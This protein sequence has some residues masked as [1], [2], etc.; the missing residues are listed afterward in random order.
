MNQSPDIAFSPYGWAYRTGREEALH[1]TGV[2]QEE[3]AIV[4][5]ELLPI[6]FCCPK[7]LKAVAFPLIFNPT[8]DSLVGTAPTAGI[9]VK[10]LDHK[11]CNLYLLHD[12]EDGLYRKSR[13]PR[14]IGDRVVYYSEWVQ[15]DHY[16]QVEERKVAFR[17]NICKYTEAYIE[18]HQDHFLDAPRSSTLD[19]EQETLRITPRGM[20]LLCIYQGIEGFG[21]VRDYDTIVDSLAK[22]NWKELYHAGTVIEESLEVVRDMIEGLATDGPGKI[23]PVALNQLARGLRAGAI[24]DTLVD[25]SLYRAFITLFCAEHTAKRAEGDKALHEAIRTA[26]QLASASAGR[27]IP[28]QAPDNYDHL[29][30]T[31]WLRRMIPLKQRQLKAIDKRKAAERLEIM[32]SGG[33]TIETVALERLMQ[34]QSSPVDVNHCRSLAQQLFQMD[35]TRHDLFTRDIVTMITYKLDGLKEL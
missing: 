9:L 12:K 16:I 30:E 4:L 28:A 3:L 2:Y 13:L 22:A 7:A 33:T 1:V 35:F 26:H 19:D 34:D 21:T 32:A 20:I 11:R 8:H 29:T 23:L 18:D 10:Q 31:E 25:E 27:P 14:N 17:T 15:N 24:S 6:E 5:G